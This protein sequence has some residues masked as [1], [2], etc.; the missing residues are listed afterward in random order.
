MLF[1][2]LILSG[3]MLLVVNRA[4][5]PKGRIL[6]AV[7]FVPMLCWVVASVAYLVN[8]VFV[9]VVVSIAA[10][11]E[12]E[13]KR[14]RIATLIVTAVSY[15]GFITYEAFDLRQ[16][17][18]RYPT[19]SVA[20]R[21]MYETNVDGVKRTV[22]TLN[23]L[24][25]SKMTGWDKAY[26]KSTPSDSTNDFV[27]QNLEKLHTNSVDWFVQSP[28]FGV[29]RMLGG[30]RGLPSLNKGD[31]PIID[32]PLSEL[33]SV[34][35]SQELNERKPIADGTSFHDLHEGSMIDFINPKGW[36]YFRDLRQVY[37]FKSHGLSKFPETQQP[38][39]KVRRIELVSLLK[40]NEPGVYLSD[41]LPNM[42]ELADAKTRPLDAFERE[43]LTQL[44]DGEDLLQQAAGTQMRLFGSIRAGAKC[45]K[46]HEVPRGELL[47]AFS[48]E[49]KPSSKD[50]L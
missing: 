36:G 35:N 41:H 39:W 27:L 28:R 47:G 11:V 23:L 30:E 50:P 20:D 45:L 1:Y 15:F 48:Y 13:R 17:R 18:N 24:T 5:T 40:G 37:A 10:A 43:S 8:V 3:I 33:V 29:G 9:L 14:I 6:R 22:P 25:I 4:K 34:Q 16:T 26:A 32:M 42:S 19:I 7:C 44:R 21:L 46:C 49:L 2:S 38:T 31:L 12:W